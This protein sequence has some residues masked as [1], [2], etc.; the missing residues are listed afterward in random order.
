MAQLIVYIGL[1][2]I[3]ITVERHPGGVWVAEGQYEG[4][5]LVTRARNAGL[6]RREWVRIARSHSKKADRAAPLQNPEI[7]PHHQIVEGWVPAPQA[8]V[9]NAEAHFLKISTA[10]PIHVAL[11]WIDA[12]RDRS[13]EK[14]VRLYD[15]DATHI[16]ACG[17][18][19]L[20]AGQMALRAY[21]FDRL[22]NYPMMQV[23][24]LN[25][26]DDASA[27]LRYVGG[28]ST[29]EA[30]LMLGPAGTIAYVIC[31][32]VSQTHK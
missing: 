16:C 29:V 5:S 17:G 24:E 13:V 21:W 32:P 11:R 3:A 1:E 8:E 9:A 18:Q 4:Q 6:V 26:L 23:L 28:N 12:Y 31:G 19:T 7:H 27:S 20:V 25:G 22:A 2:R 15:P 14:I 30:N 10:E